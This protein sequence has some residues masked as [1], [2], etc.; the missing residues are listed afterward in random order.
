M[1]VVRSVLSAAAKR[2]AMHVVAA[3]P[4]Y[5][6]PAHVP[7]NVLASEAAVMRYVSK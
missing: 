6:S 1:Y 4:Q 7:A 2:L 3:K 5:L